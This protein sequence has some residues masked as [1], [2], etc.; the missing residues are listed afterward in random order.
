MKK[1]HYYILVI[2]LGLTAVGCTKSTKCDVT[3]YN[4]SGSNPCS[5]QTPCEDYPS[6]DMVFLWDDYNTCAAWNG[7]FLCHRKAIEEHTGDTLQLVGWLDM[8][9]PYVS[10][11]EAFGYHMPWA[12]I[13]DEESHYPEL[14]N[15]VFVKI[16]ED[17]DFSVLKDKK[18]Y[19]TGIFDIIDKHDGGCCSVSPILTV[20]SIDTIK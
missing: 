10:T 19:I 9:E 1:Y 2:A 3:E 5:P 11:Y 17:I 12:M 8:K 15:D 13:T 20:I 16:D 4:G 18:M 14:N 6:E 7:Y